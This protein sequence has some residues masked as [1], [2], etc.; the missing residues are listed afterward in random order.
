MWIEK[1]QNH[2]KEKVNMFDKQEMIE[3][4]VEEGM[5]PNLAKTMVLIYE[6]SFEMKKKPTEE[7]EDEEEYYTYFFDVISYPPGSNPP[8]NQAQ[9]LTPHYMIDS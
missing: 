2:W 7:E 3:R 5:S 1:N 9:S 6:L 4:L 8:N